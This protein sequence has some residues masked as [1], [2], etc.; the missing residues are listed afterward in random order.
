MTVVLINCGESQTVEKD[1]LERSVDK[2][3]HYIES[4]KDVILIDVRTSP[5]YNGSSGHIQ[6]TILRPL[7]EIEN[8]VA[9]FDSLKHKEIILICRSGNRSG[10]ATRNLKERGF[11]KA[12]NMIGGMLAWKNAEYP[13]DRQEVEGE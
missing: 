9:E 5:E 13:I 11:R 10:A 12:H 4:N 2:V 7:H 3:K 8:W 1:S 6:G